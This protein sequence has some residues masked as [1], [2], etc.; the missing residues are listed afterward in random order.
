MLKGSVNKDAKCKADLLQLL[1]FLVAHGKSAILLVSV[2]FF[3]LEQPCRLLT[4]IIV[5]L[6]CK[7]IADGDECFTRYSKATPS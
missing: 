6:L 3:T 5:S 4:T 2:K 1:L 7:A